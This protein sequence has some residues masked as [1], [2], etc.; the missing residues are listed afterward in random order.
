[1]GYSYNRSDFVCITPPKDFN[2]VIATIKQT[3]DIWQG[4]QKGLFSPNAVA[5]LVLREANAF[6]VALFSPSSSSGL[7]GV[8]ATYACAMGL[9]NT[10]GK[11]VSP[12]VR[13]EHF[14]SDERL[15]SSFTLAQQVSSALLLLPQHAPV[16]ILYGG[17]VRKVTETLQ[18]L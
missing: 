6:G 1:M 15:Y 12:L 5:D 13:P 14:G 7:F 8:T 2:G 4:V 3:A 16:N 11:A 9:W 18:L 17:V 10:S